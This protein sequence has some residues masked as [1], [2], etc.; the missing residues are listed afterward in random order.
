GRLRW[1]RLRR[2]EFAAIDRLDPGPAASADSLD[3]YACLWTARRVLEGRAGWLPAGLDE[4]DREL[5]VPM[6]IWY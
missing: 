2:P 4:V 1:W 3:A 5:G 6:R